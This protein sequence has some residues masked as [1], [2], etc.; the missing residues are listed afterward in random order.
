MENYEEDITKYPTPDKQYEAAMKYCSHT[1]QSRP[2]RWVS[3]LSKWQSLQRGKE[4]RAK[5]LRVA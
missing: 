4:Q 3:L 5:T 1:S 2:V